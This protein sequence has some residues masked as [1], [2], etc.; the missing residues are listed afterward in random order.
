[1]ARKNTFER[2]LLNDTNMIGEHEKTRQDKSSKEQKTI[3]FDTF[4]SLHGILKFFCSNI[5]IRNA[6]NVPLIDFFKNVTQ[7]LPNMLRKS[8]VPLF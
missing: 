3:S 4:D 8:S 5:F 7:F 1:M 6:M 2:L